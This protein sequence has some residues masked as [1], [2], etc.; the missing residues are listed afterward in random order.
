M[1]VLPWD[2]CVQLGEERVLYISR[3]G[4]WVCSWVRTVFHVP[5]SRVV[6]H[7]DKQLGENNHYVLSAGHVSL[8][9]QQHLVV[10]RYDSLW[11][12]GYM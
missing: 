12:A 10:V 8:G 4:M 6:V 7:V 9:V 11:H 1:L 3:V 2:D 5:S